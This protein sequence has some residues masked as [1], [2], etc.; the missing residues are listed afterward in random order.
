M[1]LIQHCYN[2]VDI[3]AGCIGFVSVP[4]A[5][6]ILTVFTSFELYMY[7]TLI[8]LVSLSLVLFVMHVE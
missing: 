1:K 7:I 3:V 6:W 5:F 2:D 4:C 8:G